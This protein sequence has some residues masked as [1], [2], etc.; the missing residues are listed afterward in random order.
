MSRK[1]KKPR[2]PFRRRMAWQELEQDLNHLLEAGMNNERARRIVRRFRGARTQLLP[3]FCQMLHSS[4]PR[5]RD[6]GA[7]ILRACGG[8]QTVQ[9]LRDIL[10]RPHLREVIRQ[11]VLALLEGLGATPQPEEEVEPEPEVDLRELLRQ[12]RETILKAAAEERWRDDLVA[13]MTV[14]PAEEQFAL[15][16]KISV[17]GEVRALRLLEPLL[18]TQQVDLI[19]AALAGIE[20]VGR[21]E[22]LPALEAFLNRA[23][24]K[25]LKLRARRIVKKFRERVAAQERAEQV[26]EAVDLTEWPPEEVLL[27]LYRAYATTINGQGEQI[28]LL[29]RERPD[30]RLNL[31]RIF[32]D[33]QRGLLKCEFEQKLTR[34]QVRAH[35]RQLRE[36]GMIPVEVPLGYGLQM[37]AAAKNLAQRRNALPPWH[38]IAQTFCEG[39]RPSRGKGVLKL[40]PA[41]RPESLADTVQL[42]DR[43]EFQSWRLDL[44]DYTHLVKQWWD[45]QGEGPDSPQRQAV[46][47]QL[48]A[49]V[50]DDTFIAR[51]RTRLQRQ[52]LLLQR[53]QEDTAS[54]WACQAAAGL[55]KKHGIAPSDHPFLRGMATRS[56]QTFRLEEGKSEEPVPE[57]MSAE[58]A[59]VPSPTKKKRRRAGR[60]ARKDRSL[61]ETTLETTATL[62]SSQEPVAPRRAGGEEEQVPPIETEVPSS[63][64][65]DTAGDTSSAETGT[66]PKRKRRFSRR[67]HRS[68]DSSAEEGKV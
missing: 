44:A 1:L 67:R 59:A 14:L 35:V 26:L 12:D 63:A 17:A 49:T 45:G 16:E 36:E 48:L 8:R 3:F 9:A 47:T 27:P 6:L 2:I 50:A 53:L 65:E 21:A 25:R 60:R 23:P 55:L 43:P 58:S 68:R 28:L 30:G 4:D 64:P 51:L 20:Q 61:P 34:A 5:E 56:F 57:D 42:L 39:Q 15:I 22:A 62:S 11:E 40:E 7:A 18:Q 46:I 31:L 33:D 29:I 10:A 54:E 37:F 52:A 24:R 38:K 32:H 19:A 41:S 66:P 13:V